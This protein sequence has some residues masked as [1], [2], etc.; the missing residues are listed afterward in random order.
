MRSAG[1]DDQRPR[2]LLVGGGAG[3]VGRALLE[4]FAS[5]HRIRSV[6]RH[7]SRREAEL[8]VEWVPADVGAVA[9]WERLLEGVDA[10][11]NVAWYRTGSDRRFQ[12]LAAGLRRLVRASE[13]TAVR[14]FVHL[15]VPR[16]T[17]SIEGELP[18][19]VR[20]REVDRAIQESTLRYSIVRPTML[21]GARDVLL[22]VMLRTMARW[23]RFPMFGDGQYHLSPLASGDLARIVRRELA[24]GRKGVVDAGGPT[25][26]RYQDLTDLLFRSL[27]RPA[28]YF[29]LT[30]RGGI[31][32]ARLLESV[33]S[34]LLYAYE[35][36][37]LVSDLL[38]LPPYEGLGRPLEGV[39]GFVRVE[40]DRLRPG[41]PTAAS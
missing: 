11:V 28:K 26:W 19:M 14:G 17:P 34:S 38:G 36:E 21:F 15:S 37:W 20:K 29:R 5:T 3:L 2:L 27:G 6:H 10:V 23:H 41:R 39:E 13:G 30:P 12:P 18:Y 4:E 31:R 35:V 32:L 22:T 9:D 33:G 1:A 8:G 16:A 7:P 25:R 40:A 24:L